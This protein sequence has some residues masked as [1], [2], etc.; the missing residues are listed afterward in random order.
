MKSNV[1]IYKTA[2]IFIL[3]MLLL[4]SCNN[5]P[6]PILENTF[7]TNGLKV[8]TYGVNKGVLGKNTSIG[9]TIATFTDQQ[10]YDNYM[11]SLDQQIEVWDNAFVARWSQLDDDAINAK[12][13][14]LNFDSE[15]PLTDFEN[16]VGLQSLRQ[17][18]LAE[19]SVWLNNDV[20]DETTDPDDNPEY[21]FDDSEKALLNVNSEVQIGTDIY[22][23]LN[24]GQISAINGVMQKFAGQKGTIITDVVAGSYLKI[25]QTDYT[26]LIKFNDGDMSIIGQKNVSVVSPNT[27]L[28]CKYG[29]SKRAWFETVPNSKKIRAVVK[30]PQPRWGANGKVKA[31][32]KS[33]KKSGHSWK[34]YRTNLYVGL[35]GLVYNTR[36]DFPSNSINTG[37]SDRKKKLVFI[38]YDFNFD[39][40]VVENGGM[41][42][43]FKQDGITKELILSW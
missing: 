25:A 18:Y 3:G 28:E 10:A 36:C 30:V 24:S 41:K 14:E 39:S 9:T 33:F 15:K 23:Q 40:H 35:E 26:S 38:W 11:G 13:A 5:N 27:A 29:K 8:I 7:E 20:L 17:K 4:T 32:I 6:V 19:E 31:K 37:K 16:S 12:E 43:I 21:D 22:K 34:K 2:S 42:G 1:K